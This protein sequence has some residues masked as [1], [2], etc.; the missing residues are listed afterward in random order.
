MDR[1]EDYVVNDEALKIRGGEID[2]DEDAIDMS[3]AI[4]I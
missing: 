1:I 4:L 3:M 2:Y